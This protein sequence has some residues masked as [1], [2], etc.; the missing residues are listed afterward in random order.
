MSL[1]VSWFTSSLRYNQ[2]L[3]C[4]ESHNLPHSPQ[5]THDVLHSAWAALTTF[6][7]HQSRPLKSRCS[8]SRTYATSSSPLPDHYATLSVSPQAS[9]SDIKKS[10][11]TLSKT[12]HPDRTRTSSPEEAEA[13]SQKFLAI[14]EAYSVLGD[15][16]KRE[17]YDRERASYQ[18]SGGSV[19]TRDSQSSFNPG[20]RTA[21]GLSKR[22]STFR[23][24]PPSFYRSGGWGASAS[25]RQ[26]AQS[27]S[28]GQR[29]RKES[30]AN[31]K[32]N[33]TKYRQQTPP[34]K[35]GWP[36][37]A[38][39]NDVRHFNRGSHFRTQSTIEQQLSR[40]RR[41]RRRQFF[42]NMKD[43]AVFVEEAGPT[44]DIRG[45]LVVSTVVIMGIG[46]PIFF[47]TGWLN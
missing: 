42:E 40:G 27:D 8:L 1:R 12:F 16:S 9:S 18:G 22:R 19:H 2:Y 20:G 43:D 29:F 38:D 31:G 10:F 46:G 36:F 28:E 39:P 47:L 25:K 33:D 3:P 17:R 15:R 44:K 14:S 7:K 4:S 45:F 21:S 11:Y 34:E 37:A 32:E 30:E 26:Q 41:K 24:P 6:R 13:S 5:Q 35:E 23:G